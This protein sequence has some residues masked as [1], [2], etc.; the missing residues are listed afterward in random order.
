MKPK[1]DS[2]DPNIELAKMKNADGICGM[3]KCQN[4]LSDSSVDGFLGIKV[5]NECGKIIDDMLELGRKLDYEALMR[6]WFGIK[7]FNEQRK[8]GGT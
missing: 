6:Y 8:I 7:L 3:D 4:N 2:L 5:C 1:W